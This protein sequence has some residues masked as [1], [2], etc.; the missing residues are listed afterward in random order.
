MS[1]PKLSSVF[2]TASAQKKKQQ[3]LPSSRNRLSAGSMQKTISSLPENCIF[4]N[5]KDSTSQK[6]YFPSMINKAL[7]S[8]YSSSQNY[9]YTKDINDLLTNS[10]TP[11]V[12]KYKDYLTV[13][14]EEE[15][16]KRFYKASEYGYKIRM[17]TE[18]Y[19]FHRDISRLFMQPTTNV[20]NK[21]HDKKRRLEY[22]RVT[23]MLREENE[24]KNPSPKP[25]EKPRAEEKSPVIM[26]RILDNLDI[27]ND[28][29][30][31]QSNKPKTSGPAKGPNSFRPR[32]NSKNSSQKPVVSGLNLQKALVG[33][34][35]GMKNFEFSVPFLKLLCRLRQI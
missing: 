21:Y 20:L 18:Y 14:E 11:V 34:V 19:K 1:V 4:C 35:D 2:P 12:I 27:T 31:E 22:I 32:S 7:Y 13:D 17:L 23:K 29:A 9:Y 26:D 24:V 33:K 30:I 5:K 6:N 15:F 3:S 8:K 28:Q 16:L 25:K 10:R